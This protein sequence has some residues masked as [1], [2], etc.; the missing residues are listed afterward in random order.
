MIQPGI[1]G[2]EIIGG[3]EPKQDFLQI[4]SEVFCGWYAIKRVVL[5]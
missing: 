3:F 5:P 4:M 1:G 2:P